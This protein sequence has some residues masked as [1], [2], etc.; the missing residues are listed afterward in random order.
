MFKAGDPIIHPVRGAGV[1]IGI[2]ER[3]W[4]G[5]SALYYRIQLLGQQSVNLMIPIDAAETLG[6]R[7]TIAKSK[8]GQVWHVLL[9][10][11][12]KLP[13][14][15]RQRYQLLK[16]KLHTGDVFHVAEVVRDMAWRQRRKGSLTTVGKRLYDEGL[17]LLAGELAAAQDIDLTNAEFQITARLGES[18]SREGVDLH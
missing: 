10:D 17:T 6:L 16:D 1:V 2:E 12:E 4:R 7:R 8:L 5:S 15:H 9:A 11:P 13:A 18:L 14:D 3:E